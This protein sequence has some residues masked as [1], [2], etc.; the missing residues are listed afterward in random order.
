MSIPFYVGPPPPG[1][2]DEQRKEYYKMVKEKFGGC[3]LENKSKEGD[4]KTELKYAWWP[5]KVC[6]RTIWL[7]SYE[8]LFEYKIRDR[9]TDTGR[10]IIRWH[11]GGWDL[12][13]EKND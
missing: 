2:N 7:K 8:Q 9:I 10:M 3:Q 13:A 6:G 5:T 12:V 4:L 1:S 11:G